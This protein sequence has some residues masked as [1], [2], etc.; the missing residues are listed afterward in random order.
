[1]NCD[2]IKTMNY[3]ERAKKY[4]AKKRLGQNFLIDEN[5]I[6]KSICENL[7]IDEDE[8]DWDKVKD[9]YDDIIEQVSVYFKQWFKRKPHWENS[10]VII[11]NPDDFEG[12][13]E[14][15]IKKLID[16]F[17]YDDIFNEVAERNYKDVEQVILIGKLEYI[18]IDD[19]TDDDIDSIY[20]WSVVESTTIGLDI[21][22]KNAWKVCGIDDY[23]D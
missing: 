8:I 15:K 16:N 7:S 3:F 23:Q 19:P 14:Y 4:R 12:H 13:S 1:M 20:F 10:E 21:E 9:C 18:D 11:D 22:G 5:A 2:I 6:E 17:R